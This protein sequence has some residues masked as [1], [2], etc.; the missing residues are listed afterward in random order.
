MEK[1]KSQT[2]LNILKRLAHVLGTEIKNRRLEI[3]ST[4]GKGYCTVFV[5]NEHIRMLIMK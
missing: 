5:F 1:D 3:P 2:V 4:F